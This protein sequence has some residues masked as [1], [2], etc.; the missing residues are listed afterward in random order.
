VD[1]SKLTKQEK[2][3]LLALLEE[4]SR[5]DKLSRPLYKPHA[6][7]EAIHRSK[8]KV[9]FCTAANG[10]GKSC[11]AVHEAV[12]RAQGYNPVTGEHTPVPATIAVL[13]DKPSKFEEVFLE[14]A[15]KWF[16]F[17][18]DQLLKKGKPHLSQI[19]FDNGSVINFYS[20]E[21][22]PLTF[23]S[24]QIDAMIADE[25]FPRDIYVGLRR[26]GRK[27]G[28]DAKYL[29]IGTPLGQA[30][31]KEELWDPWERGETTEIECFRGSTEINKANLSDGYIESFSKALTEQEKRIRLHGEWFNLGGLALAHL[32]KRATHVVPAETLEWDPIWPC[33]VAVDPHISKAHHAVLLGCDRDGQLYALKELK[34]K[35]VPR[36]FARALKQ[37]YAG[38]RVVDLVCDSLGASETTGG[39]GFKSFIQVLNEEGVRIRSTSYEDK[40]DED[41]IARI[42]DTLKM[43]DEPDNFGRKRPKLLVSS[44]CPQ[45]IKDIENVQWVRQKG[46]EDFK[47]KLDITHKDM[48]AALKYALACNLTPKKG[49]AV[50]YHVKKKPYGLGGPKGT[51]ALRLKLGLGRR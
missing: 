43:P 37:W 38:Y 34:E 1:L 25:P 31:M 26:A 39:E 3:E 7:Q 5:R 48:L 13:M 23:E 44:R 45:L 29:I 32:F 4:K 15:R 36:E 30:W 47:P 18:P 41:F 40:S 46:T 12:W 35:L 50:A 51:A 9:R 11:L 2:L 27:K 19:A 8:A 20:H 49:K 42:Q 28:V 21:Q 6:V 22:D 17:R 24:I 10:M 14:E 33:V 16:V